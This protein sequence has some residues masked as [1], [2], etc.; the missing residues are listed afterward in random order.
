MD[1]SGGVGGGEGGA[2]VDVSGG[3]RGVP[4]LTRF[5]ICVC[6]DGAFLRVRQTMV[7][8]R[9][10]HQSLVRSLEGCLSMQ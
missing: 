9:T 10:E 3:E 2:A 6:K 7:A 8:R 5:G 4:R 1:V